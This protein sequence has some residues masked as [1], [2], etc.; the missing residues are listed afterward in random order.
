MWRAR[1]AAILAR[2]KPTDIHLRPAVAGD[3]EAFVRLHDQLGAG[4]PTPSLARFTDELSP[5]SIM[6][7]EGD[8]SVGYVWYEI[9]SGVAYV[10]HLVVDEGS[11]GRGLGRKLMDEA[12]ARALAASCASWCLNVRPDNMP[13]RRLYESLGLR[14][15]YESA[16]VR[17]PWSLVEGLP[18]GGDLEISIGPGPLLDEEVESALD[19]AQGIIAAGRRAGRVIAVAR[20]GGRPVGL[21]VF[22]PEFPGAFP[23]KLAEASDARAVLEAL[24]PHALPHLALMALVIEDAPSLEELFTSRGAEVRL[25]LIH[26]R[27]SLPF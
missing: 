21:A 13:A 2:V 18:G 24:R 8:R 11:R 23:F 5:T 1:G 6:A 4:D 27:G 10:R 17:F 25:R 15:A 22:N 26:H 12:R 9:L 3:Y 7:V 20:R 14:P 19:V 16:A